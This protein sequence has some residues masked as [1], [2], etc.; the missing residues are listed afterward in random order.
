M[1]LTRFTLRQIEAFLA[2]A[3]L[4]NFSSASERLGLTTQAVS[5]LIAE[6]ETH[7]NFRVF[8]RTTRRVALSSAGSD[9][10]VS[11]QTLMRHVQ[12]AESVA[13][14]VRHRAVGIV[15]VGAP[16][17]LACTALPE[18]IKNFQLKNP[19]IVIR[20]RD[21]PVEKL[22]D[23]VSAGDIDIAIGPDRA[24]DSDVIRQPLFDS[25]WVM[26]CSPKHSLA[27]K[28]LIK[29]SDLQN[30]QVVSAGY[31]HERNVAQMH[32]NLP[33]EKRIAPIEV[34]DHIST[35]MG[36]AAQGAVVT[37]APAYVGVIAEKFGLVMRR[38]V[39][40]ETVRKV[41]IYLPSSRSQSPA[42]EAFTEYLSQWLP[43]WAEK[44]LKKT[45]KRKKE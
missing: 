19:R 45:M 30:R 16:L 41:C 43:L 3:E 23:S 12:S 38:I 29:W 44:T 31:D 2:V 7:L 11:A 9:F 26:L 15:R 34:V 25:D 5:Q 27:N 32:V 10:L 40:P 1:S 13:N 36:L 20:I 33:T 14:D 42:S 4:R 37:L 18:A 8:D 6:L 22:V 21:L 39:N 17:V 24:T 28:R 35:A